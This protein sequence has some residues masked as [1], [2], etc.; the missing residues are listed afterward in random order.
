MVGRVIALMGITLMVGTSYPPPIEET[1]LLPSRIEEILKDD[2]LA[3]RVDI[4]YSKRMRQSFPGSVPIYVDAPMGGKLKMSHRR[5][6]LAFDDPS[7]HVSVMRTRVLVPEEVA[8]RKERTLLKSLLDSGG[9]KYCKVERVIHSGEPEYQGEWDEFEIRFYRPLSWRKD[10]RIGERE[11]CH[12][13]LTGDTPE[14]LRNFYQAFDKEVLLFSDIAEEKYPK[15]KVI[16][17]PEDPGYYF[18]WEIHLAKD[19][20]K[21]VEQEVEARLKARKEKPV[22]SGSSTAAPAAK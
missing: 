20:V 14:P 12:L 17:D 16:D 21:K 19:D 6:W 2:A 3:V 4:L 11:I 5:G 22:N 18:H 13:D 9:M 15:K 1:L 10:P 8:I 7:P